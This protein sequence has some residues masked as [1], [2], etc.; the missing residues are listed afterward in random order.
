MSDASLPQMPQ[1]ALLGR[2][3]LILI[4]DIALFVLLLNV[5]PFEPAANKGLALMVFIG[6]LWLTEALHVTLTALLVPIVAV[7]L[8]LL[9]APKALSMF[10]DPIIFLFFGGFALATALHIQGIDRLI[11]NQLLVAARG[12]MGVAAMMLFG[13][14]ALLSMWISNTATAAMMLPLA[15]GVLSQLDQ[16]REHKTFVF[17][18]L[19]IA[20]SCSIGGLG[21]LVG[22]PPNAIAAAQLGLD[23]AGWMKFG[24]P[25]MLVTMPLMIGL[26]Y[27][28]LKPN[29]KHT[30]SIKTERLAW[31]PHRIVTL[32][33]FSLTVVC[34][35]FSSQI[36]AALGGVKQF[37]SLVALSAAVLIGAT[38]T[39]SWGQ[40]QKNTEWG[41][42]MLFG[43]G[44]TLS[45][46]LKESGASVVLANGMADIFG[47]SHW[48]I[49]I[50]AVATFIIFLTE[51]TSNTASA[52]LLV[53]VF[54]TV[55]DALGMPSA[56]L[57]LVIGMGASCA[58]ML[59]VATP[60][61]AIVFGTGH[62]KQSE[63]V[64]VGIWLNLMCVG[65]VTLFA[66]FV[67][68]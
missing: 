22:S 53:P 20:Y 2:N 63:M 38:G 26:L 25:V 65:I 43:G 51:F 1:S 52:A 17:V 16:E 44:L 31:T 50:L 28:L 42:L 45:A 57:T 4:A 47:A 35:I 39:A 61:N 33:I 11:A 14:S 54:A 66:W 37:D 27:L 21:T 67:W 18:L 56:L 7:G 64:R 13:V 32:G 15:M 34:W 48:F 46:V 6:V 24:I 68:M 29:L 59:P 9:E 40:I 12:R 49:I 58:F 8:G 5:L 41:V 10:A 36:S 19:G 60:P 3:P 30:F 23:F 62:I 55:A